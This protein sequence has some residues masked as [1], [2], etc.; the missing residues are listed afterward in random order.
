MGAFPPMGGSKGGSLLGY[1]DF[2]ERA[3]QDLSNDISQ[4]LVLPVVTIVLSALPFVVYT[5]SSESLIVPIIYQ[6][7]QQYLI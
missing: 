2:S 4:S 3:H 5:T 6:K 7:L 1:D